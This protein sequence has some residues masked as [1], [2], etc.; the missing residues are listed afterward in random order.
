MLREPSQIC[1]ALSCTRVNLLILS[2]HILTD[3]LFTQKSGILYLYMAK[4]DRFE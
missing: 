2:K 4:V 3:R 1:L